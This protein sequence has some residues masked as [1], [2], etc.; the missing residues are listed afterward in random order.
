MD[1]H[2]H[3]PDTRLRELIEK[4]GKGASKEEG[5]HLEDCEPCLTRYVAL[6]KKSESD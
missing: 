5:A 1:E 3:I 4:Q 2:N 6:I